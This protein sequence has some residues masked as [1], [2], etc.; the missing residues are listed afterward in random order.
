MGQLLPLGIQYFTGEILGL[1][2]DQGKR[3]PY[4]CVPA[5]L[6]DVD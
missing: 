5:L 3:G 4:Y 6:S 2:D 1:T